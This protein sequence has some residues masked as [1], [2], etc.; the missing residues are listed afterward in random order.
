MGW[1][2][3]EM[4]LELNTFVILQPL[5]QH[6]DHIV[7]YLIFSHWVHLTN[8]SSRKRQSKLCTPVF[9]GNTFYC[10][11][12]SLQNKEQKHRNKNLGTTSCTL[13]GVMILSATLVLMNIWTLAEQWWNVVKPFPPFQKTCHKASSYYL[14]NLTVHNVPL[15][16]ALILGIYVCLC[17]EKVEAVWRPLPHISDFFL[18]QCF[19]CLNTGLHW[20]NHVGGG[21][22]MMFVDVKGS[23]SR[24]SGEKR[25]SSY[26]N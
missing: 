16:A 2:V 24:S 4:H 21:G 10:T 15:W 7:I 12:A 23:F 25:V 19:I 8:T 6:Y 20:V 18:L 17:W 14:C 3:M 26:T 5:M 11:I 22:L 13:D 1:T 9:F